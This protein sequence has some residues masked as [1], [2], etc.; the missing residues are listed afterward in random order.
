MCNCCDTTI[1]NDQFYRGFV[2]GSWNTACRA[3]ARTYRWEHL[4]GPSGETLVKSDDG[5]AHY[6]EV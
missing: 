4:E 1:K 5:R 3:C 2:H 6:W